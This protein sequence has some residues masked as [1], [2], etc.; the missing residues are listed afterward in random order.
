VKYHKVLSLTLIAT[1]VFCQPLVAQSLNLQTTLKRMVD[2]LAPNSKYRA[3]VTPA[4]RGTGKKAKA[5]QQQ[6]NPTPAERRAS[7]TWAQRLK[8]VFNID[9]EACSNCGGDVRIIASIE[10]PAVIKQILAHLERM[11]R[12][13]SA[14]NQCRF[15]T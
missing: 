8:R 14:S 13:F 11:C 4:Q 7:M 1:L 5:A 3:W 9:I 6:P 2:L 15:A 12:Q 10:D